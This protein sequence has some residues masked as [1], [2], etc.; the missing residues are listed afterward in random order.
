MAKHKRVT[1]KLPKK[2]LKLMAR[3][4]VLLSETPTTEA[5]KLVGESFRDIRKVQTEVKQID[6]TTK[7]RIKEAVKKQNVKTAK[8]ARR[9]SPSGEAKSKFASSRLKLR[10]LAKLHGQQAAPRGGFETRSSRGLGGG[11]VLSELGSGG[12]L[13]FLRKPRIR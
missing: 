8:S 3:N 9:S 10:G 5:R 13:M 2:T 4:S 7:V 12:K 11:G 6:E 1:I